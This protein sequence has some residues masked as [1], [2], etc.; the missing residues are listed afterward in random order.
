MTWRAVLKPSSEA[1]KLLV[2]DDQRDLLRARLPFPRSPY[3][4]PHLLETLAAWDRQEVLAAISVD[5]PQRSRQLAALLGAPSLPGSDRV[6]YR[7]EPR[8]R[9]RQLTDFHELYALL[10]RWEQP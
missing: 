6:R 5:G 7:L 3:L 10:A 1:I 2:R 4:L 8:R 9:P